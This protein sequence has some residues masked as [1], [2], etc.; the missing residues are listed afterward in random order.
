MTFSEK[1]PTNKK[2]N[3]FLSQVH[4]PFFTLGVSSA[5]IMML[6]FALGY[7][8][9]LTL[10]VDALF[11]HVYSLIFIVFINVFTGFLFTTYP[12]YTGMPNVEDSFYK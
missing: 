7:K 10:S 3:Y 8:G 6:V 9:V 4:Q 5:I 12:K 11:F 1:K 2:Q